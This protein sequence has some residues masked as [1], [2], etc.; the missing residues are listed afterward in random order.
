MEFPSFIDVAGHQAVLWGPLALINHDCSSELTFRVV[1]D[2]KEAQYGKD[3][4]MELRGE[5]EEFMVVED[6]EIY[7][8]YGPCE[9]ESDFVCGTCVAS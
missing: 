5:E 8:Y 7:A 4:R 3:Y 2:P 1:G 6:E 9:G